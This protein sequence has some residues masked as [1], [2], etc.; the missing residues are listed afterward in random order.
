M[1]NSDMASK[2]PEQEAADSARFAANGA[3]LQAIINPLN[4]AEYE[5]DYGFRDV[6]QYLTKMGNDWGGFDLCPD[7][8]R[9]HVWTP[10][11][12][13]RFVESVLRGTVSSSGFLLQF[14]C[15]N[16]EN[17]DYSG[18]MPLGFQCI[19]GLQRYTAVQAFVNG[20]IKPFGLSPEDLS[21]SSFS[22]NHYRFRIAVHCFQD[23]ATLLSHY[24]DLNEGGTPHS[25]EELT[26]VRKLREVA[27][28]AKE[29]I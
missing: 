24:L 10:M 11:Q 13:Q 27:L 1:A 21:Y 23:R 16:W 17:D 2:S 8:Q 4:T 12:Q 28:N 18:E 15:P 22:I 19:D 14:N 26:R 20:D 7:F 3:R 29:S 9:G 6:S 25:Q 5:V